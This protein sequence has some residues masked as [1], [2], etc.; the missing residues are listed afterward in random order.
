MRKADDKSWFACW[1]DDDDCRIDTDCVDGRCERG[2]LEGIGPRSPQ[3]YRASCSGL[4]G[5]RQPAGDFEAI[6]TGPLGLSDPRLNSLRLAVDSWRRSAAPRRRVV[7]Q[8]CLVPDLAAFLEAIALWD[9]RSFFPI[10]IDEPAWTLPFLRAFRPAR[11]VRFAGRDTAGG[12]GGFHGLTHSGELVATGCGHNR[13]KR[14]HAPGLALARRNPRPRPPLGRREGSA[15]HRPALFFLTPEAPMLAGAVALAA[16]RFQ[17]LVRLRALS[18]YPGSAKKSRLNEGF[19]DVLNLPEALGFARRVE[20][21]VASVVPQYN[22]LG[23]D[24]DFLTIAADWPYR[25]L[26]EGGHEPFRGIYAL[27]DLIGRAV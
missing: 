8:V 14:W 16:G 3:S 20:L 19:E 23:D 13:S 21:G 25:Y 4:S 12:R 26:V 7:D 15:L 5:N 6:P 2:R 11:V 18:G 9:Q 10:L 24:C 17:P 22:R 27:D 1:L